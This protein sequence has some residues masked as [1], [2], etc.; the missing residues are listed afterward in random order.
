M[1]AIHIVGCTC[2]TCQRQKA[3]RIELQRARRAAA[4]AGEVYVLPA[5]RRQGRIASKLGT[6]RTKWRDSKQSISASRGRALANN[7]HGAGVHLSY[8]LRMLWDTIPVPVQ[9]AVVTCRDKHGFQDIVTY[10]QRVPVVAYRSTSLADFQAAVYKLWASQHRAAYG[11][12]GVEALAEIYSASGY[13]DGRKSEDDDKDKKKK[14]KPTKTAAQPQ[15]V[16]LPVY[17]DGG[18]HFQPQGTATAIITE[19][20]SA[21]PTLADCGLTPL[22]D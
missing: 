7:N 10:C 2:D 20:V 16:P 15:G 22:I 13:D 3:R 11:F 12:F 6:K 18:Y 21:M 5:T 8:E 19:R 4:D 1:A 17:P 14:G 9:R